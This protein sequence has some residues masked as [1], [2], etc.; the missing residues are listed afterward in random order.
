MDSEKIFGLVM[1]ELVEAKKATDDK[2]IT[3]REIYDAI[4]VALEK[5]ELMDKVV[6][7]FSGEESGK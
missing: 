2:K 1:A 3:V 5:L 7:D 4:G 6:I